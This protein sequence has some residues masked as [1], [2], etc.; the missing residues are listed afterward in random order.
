MIINDGEIKERLMKI[1]ASLENVGQ[2]MRYYEGLTQ[3]LQQRVNTIDRATEESIRDV[4]Q[5]IRDITREVEKLSGQISAI[6]K[7]ISKYWEHQRELE[8]KIAGMVA[9]VADYDRHHK[10]VQKLAE[11]VER[12]KMINPYVLEQVAALIRAMRGEK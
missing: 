1:E 10:D 3:L 4:R 7:D 12:M 2:S 6:K 9:R 5:Q 8:R 11:L